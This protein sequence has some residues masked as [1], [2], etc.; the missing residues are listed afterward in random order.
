M[1]T[2]WIEICSLLA[3]VGPGSWVSGTSHL[4][5]VAQSYLTLCNPTD[6]SPPSSSVHGIS[7]ARILEWVAIS[8]SRGSSWPRDRTC[9]SCISVLQ[10][11]SLPFEP[12]ENPSHQS[13]V[14]ERNKYLQRETLGSVSGERVAWV[15]VYSIDVTTSH[16]GYLFTISKALSHTSSLWNPTKAL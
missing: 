13:L 5:S 7:Q 15:L 16:S 3:Q 2:V 6:C 4:C 1:T 10:A 12:S 11:D 8:L 9:A 14:A